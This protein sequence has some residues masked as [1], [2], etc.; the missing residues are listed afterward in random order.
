MRA[1]A[2]AYDLIK[3]FEGLRLRA[4]KDSGDKW[5]IGYGST[6]E[7]TPTLVIDSQEILANDVET[8]LR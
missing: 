2:T 3:A 5:T 1:S 6:T 7:V 4:Y 8:G